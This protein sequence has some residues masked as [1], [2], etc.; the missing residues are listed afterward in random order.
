[1]FVDIGIAIGIITA[2]VT[3]LYSA[4]GERKKHCSKCSC[5]PGNCE[6]FSLDRI[7]K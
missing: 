2:T 3:I 6:C 7:D 1:M 4:I 5:Y